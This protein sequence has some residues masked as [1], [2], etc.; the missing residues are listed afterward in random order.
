MFYLCSIICS[1]TNTL[2]QS[3]LSDKSEQAKLCCYNKQFYY[4]ISLTQKNEFL[5][6]DVQYRLRG[7]LYPNCLL[8]NQTDKGSILTHGY[9]VIEALKSG[10]R[11]L[12]IGSMKFC[13]YVA[14]ITSNHISVAKE[15]HVFISNLKWVKGNTI[16]PCTLKKGDIFINGRIFYFYSIQPVQL[17]STS[18]LDN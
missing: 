2:H 3:P 4:L 11:R 7:E 9:K 8:E 6:L 12:H 15:N 5:T 18:S 10:C 1:T 13:S 14:H 16:L 17:I